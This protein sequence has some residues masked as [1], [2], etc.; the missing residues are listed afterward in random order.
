MFEFTPTA[1]LVTTRQGL[2]VPFILWVED[3]E[4][5][6]RNIQIVTRS[7]KVVQPSPLVARPFDDVTSHEEVR[8]EDDELLRQL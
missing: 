2:S 7:G 1:P 3:D 6:G 5:E 4:F 8:R